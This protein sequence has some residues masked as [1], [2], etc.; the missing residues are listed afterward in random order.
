MSVT[1][2][3]IASACNV[4]IA[5]VSR[6][7]NNSSLVSAKT[8]EKVR[9]KM[10]EMKY[11]PNPF[12]RGI[13]LDSMKLIGVVVTDLMQYEQH[14][15]VALLSAAFQQ[16]GYSL[17]VATLP[18]AG[19]EEAL[20][21][22]LEKHLD[23]LVLVSLPAKTDEFCQVLTEGAQRIPIMALHG[24]TLIP[25]LHTITSTT[26]AAITNVCKKLAKTGL[27]R[28]LYLYQGSSYEEESYLALFRRI[29]KSPKQLMRVSAHTPGHIQQALQKIQQSK[30]AIDAIITATDTLAIS[31]QQALQAL[32][33]PIPVISLVDSPL[34]EYAQITSLDTQVRAQCQTAATQLLL[35][36]Q[37]KQAAVPIRTEFKATWIYRDS[38]PAP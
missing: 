21:R 31:A 30:A 34:T 15:A 13:G 9:A 28:P 14:Q 1:I 33:L 5:T 17:L 22:L 23:A 26:D 11:N 38:F 10:A 6:V 12:A 35:Q 37:Q 19:G 3:D 4:S 18:E 2:Y 24:M 25:S 29:S 32:S 16:E 36:L 20:Q 27:K 8:K 7:L